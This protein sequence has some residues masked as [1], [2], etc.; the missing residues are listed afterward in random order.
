VVGGPEGQEGGRRREER[1]ERGAEA[2]ST[3][4]GPFVGG[5]RRDLTPAARG[6]ARGG[7][8]VRPM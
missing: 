2:V 3:R 7:T 4:H 8:G 5:S 1:G 6:L